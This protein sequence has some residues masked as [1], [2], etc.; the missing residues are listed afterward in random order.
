VTKSTSL[1]SLKLNDLRESDNAV[2]PFEVSGLASVDCTDVVDGSSTMGVGWVDID[3]SGCIVAVETGGV[4][5]C[6][7]EL[8]DFS[9]LSGNIGTD[10]CCEVLLDVITVA[11]EGW[12]AIPGGE[13]TF[14][15]TLETLACLAELGIGGGNGPRPRIEEGVLAA[16]ADAYFN[17]VPGRVG[18]DVGFGTPF[19]AGANGAVA[20]VDVTT[21]RG[22]ATLERRLATDSFALWFV[23]SFCGVCGWSS[24]TD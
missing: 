3:A 2:S 24:V 21:G 9:P 14:D 7:G 23:S 1:G 8:L 5:A 13:A 18:C 4:D 11:E 22:A 12:T 20:A 15:A 17:S 6:L 19:A 10:D 16:T